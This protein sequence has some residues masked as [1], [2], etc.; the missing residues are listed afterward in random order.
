MD[1]DTLMDKCLNGFSR[2]LGEPD[3]L[4]L[5][6]INQQNFLVL[7]KYLIGQCEKC[8]KI[9]HYDRKILE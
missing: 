3:R 9:N 1:T 5:L 6:K 2:T 7:L 8:L 4:E